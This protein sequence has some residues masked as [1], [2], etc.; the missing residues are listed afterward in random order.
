MGSRQ[1]YAVGPLRVNKSLLWIPIF[2]IRELGALRCGCSMLISSTLQTAVFLSHAPRLSAQFRSHNYQTALSVERWVQ[3]SYAILCSLIRDA[4]ISPRYSK[5]DC[6][7]LKVK[8]I[9]TAVGRTVDI[10]I[11][12]SAQN[13]RGY[14][15]S[16]STS[17]AMERLVLAV[18]EQFPSLELQRADLFCESSKTGPLIGVEMQF[19]VS[20]SS[21]NKERLLDAHKFVNSLQNKSNV[22]REVLAG[23]MGV[24]GCIDFD[25]SQLFDVALENVE[26]REVINSPELLNFSFTFPK[27]LLREL[28]E[29]SMDN[30]SPFQR[31]CMGMLCSNGLDSDIDFGEVL[32]SICAPIYLGAL[33]KLSFSGLFSH[34]STDATVMCGKSIEE[35]GCVKM[36]LIL[37]EDANEDMLPVFGGRE[38]IGQNSNDSDI[39]EDD[40]SIDSDL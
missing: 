27:L 31:T 1:L 26:L 11:L 8:L 14:P 25:I 7:D 21:V 20:S 29:C 37:E 4:L 16:G 23:L 9:A 13:D 34:I 12:Y 38:D 36:G 35:Q 6:F 15:S 17:G 22:H 30:L 18:L 39:D 24:V 3:Y 28:E 2:G 5:D 40:V 19:N 10:S 33:H 32:A